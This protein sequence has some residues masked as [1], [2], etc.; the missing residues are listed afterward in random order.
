MR[1][2]TFLFSLLFSGCVVDDPKPKPI[3]HN[4]TCSSSLYTYYNDKKID[5]TSRLVN[6]YI[7]IGFQKDKSRVITSD[8]LD[9]K[10]DF[11]TDN[12]TVSDYRKLK[13]TLNCSELNN[14]RI[15]LLKETDVLFVSFLF[16]RLSYSSNQ[17]SAD[18]DFNDL[19]YAYHTDE[20]TVEIKQAEDIELLKQM[21]LKTKTILVKEIKP[22][23]YLL[24]TDVNSQGDALAMTT[25]FNESNQFKKC[26]TNWTG[27]EAIE[28]DFPFI[29]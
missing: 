21:I 1:Y 13:N 17:Y 12:I 11:R 26:L 18:L 25:Y 29:N 22:N 5:L 16:S 23:Q 27:I 15:A 10:T 20:F 7:V 24:K 2:L 9:A 19:G 6:N 8:L 28:G 14:L 3:P 4:S